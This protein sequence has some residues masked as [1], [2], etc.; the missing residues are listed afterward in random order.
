MIAIGWFVGDNSHEEAVHMQIPT[1]GLDI[2]KNVFRTLQDSM[3]SNNE[4]APGVLGRPQGG[5]IRQEQRT[6]P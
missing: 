6:P 5:E 3:G 2:A 1:I 4:N